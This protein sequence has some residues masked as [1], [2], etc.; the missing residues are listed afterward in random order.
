MNDRDFRQQVLEQERQELSRECLEEAVDYH[1]EQGWTRQEHI[2]TCVQLARRFHVWRAG[3][4][5][6]DRRRMRVTPALA[7]RSDQLAAWIS[8]VVEQLR[9]ERFGSTTAPF[10]SL[11]A[12]ANWIE[13]MATTSVFPG[14]IRQ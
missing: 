9:Q 7:H 12:A 3:S 6:S 1:I 2:K 13:W 14:E 10:S 11:D 5:S 4:P 8:P